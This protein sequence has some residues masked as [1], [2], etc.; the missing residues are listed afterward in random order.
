MEEEEE[1][2][3]AVE[4]EMQSLKQRTAKQAKELDEK[5]QEKKKLEK[6]KSKDAKKKIDDLKKTTQ[7]V[8]AQMEKEANSTN[9][10]I[11]KMLAQKVP[12][13]PPSGAFK[14]IDKKL[15]GVISKHGVKVAGDV[16][17]KP[18]INIK[19]KKFMLKMTIKF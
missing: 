16:W 1:V 17:L 18:D 9:A 6:D 2:M 11:Q 7:K 15:E 8:I 19:K 12:A 4:S 14:G 5:L 3:M 10:R 13:A